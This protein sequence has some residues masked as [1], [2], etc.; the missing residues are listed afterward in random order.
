MVS[1][2][3]LEPHS[4]GLEL[5]VRMLAEGV[6]VDPELSRW[7]GPQFLEKRRAYGNPDPERFRL[8]RIPQEIYTS[9]GLIVAV[10]VREHS[11][12]VLS[13]DAGGFR[14][15]DEHG[16]DRRISMPQRP[17]FY[18]EQMPSGEK[19]ST[20]IT[21]YGGGALGVFAYGDCDLVQRDVACAYC[22]IGPNRRQ[23]D[24]FEDVVRA[25][26]LRQALEI[27]L[28]D[29]SAP[30]SQVMLNGGNFSEMD[31][32]FR[33]YAALAK[34]A[35]ETIDRCRRSDVELH[36]IVF[37]PRDLQLLE[38]MADLNLQLAMNL[39]V[40]D[41]EL[42]ARYC[43]GKA[44]TAGQQ[45]IR[46]AVEKAVSFLGRDHVFSILVGGLEPV[47]SLAAGMMELGAMGV[48]P[49]INVFHPDPGTPLASRPA[50]S[51]TEILSMGQA[52]Q[53][54][55]ET[56]GLRSFYTGCGRNSLDTEAER[57]LF[58]TH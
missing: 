57:R 32:S 47:E 21:L 8:Q 17:L 35:R 7:F 29:T 25:D 56:F 2:A 31:R 6:R 19:V 1:A 55:Y 54:V 5:K 12:L 9:D 53:E 4:D 44:V 36:L 34:V 18:Q 40:F 15:T 28:S 23:T 11:P 52:L 58:T 26:Q 16:T 10:N 45:H 37:P 13:G 41:T 43:P 38:L 51:R 50:P 30:I 27:A 24:E 49:V 33:Y 22:S 3:S 14:I 42:F 39:E 20:V 46:R 48:T